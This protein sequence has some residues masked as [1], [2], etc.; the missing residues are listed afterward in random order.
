MNKLRDQIEKLIEDAKAKA[1]RKGVNE[2][3]KRVEIAL[4]ASSKIKRKG[5]LVDLI[6]GCRD[7]IKGLLG[8]NPVFGGWHFEDGKVVRNETEKWR[9]GVGEEYYAVHFS[10]HVSGHINEND[11]FDRVMIAF[12]NCFKTS[13]EAEQKRKEIYGE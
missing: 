11:G 5:D 7:S 6:R 10:D 4:E 3:L 8:G 9:P 1:F 13:E 2:A 12:G